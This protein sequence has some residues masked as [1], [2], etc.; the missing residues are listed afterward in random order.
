MTT[1]ALEP[2]VF[3]VRWDT[4]TILRCPKMVL[5]CL[6]N[7]LAACLSPQSLDNEGRRGPE[8]LARLDRD[9]SQRPVSATWM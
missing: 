8:S 6:V 4:Q 5:R 9:L 3:R 1:P 2:P 7:V